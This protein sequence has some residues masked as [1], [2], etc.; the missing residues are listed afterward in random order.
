MHLQ[1]ILSNGLFLSIIGLLWRIGGEF[2]D[3]KIVTIS[4]PVAALAILLKGIFDVLT[5]LKLKK[6]GNANGNGNID[7]NIFKMTVSLNNIEK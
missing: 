7:K 3:D 5:F 1:N 2:S 6:N 4:L